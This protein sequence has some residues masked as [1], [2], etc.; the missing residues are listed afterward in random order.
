MSAPKITQMMIQAPH[1][2]GLG[3]DNKVY[4]YLPSSQDWAPIRKNIG[5][6]TWHEKTAL[7]A[8]AFLF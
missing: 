8:A 6:I 1:I 5:Q 4:I 3:E 7:A 2:Y